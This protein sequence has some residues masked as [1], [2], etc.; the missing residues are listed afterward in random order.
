MEHALS[1]PHEEV[2]KWRRIRLYR[3]PAPAYLRRPQQALAVGIGVELL[4]PSGASSHLWVQTQNMPRLRWTAEEILME[5][6]GTGSGVIRSRVLQ[7]E[8]GSLL[9]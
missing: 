8:N 7:L 2:L 4:A 1:Y 9:L 5:L 3:L 6:G